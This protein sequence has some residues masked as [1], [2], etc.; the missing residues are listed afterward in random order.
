MPSGFPAY[1]G[2]HELILDQKFEKHEREAKIA[3]AKQEIAELHGHLKQDG[4]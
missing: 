2:K 4:R 1:E 3:R